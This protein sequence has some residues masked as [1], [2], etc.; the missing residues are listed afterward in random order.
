MIENKE[1]G[2]KIAVDTDEKFWSEQKK[3]MEDA[4]KVE[5][6]NSKIR[7]KLLELSNEE[8]DKK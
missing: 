7:A 5:A 2:V 1:L 3:T 8:L 6:R 4:D